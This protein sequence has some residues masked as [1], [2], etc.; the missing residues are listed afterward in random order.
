MAILLRLDS[1][2]ASLEV[3]VLCSH[4][5]AARS[6][7]DAVR[8][9]LAGAMCSA[10]RALTVMIGDWNFVRE[11]EDRMSFADTEWKGNAETAEHDQCLAELFGPGRFYQAWQADD[12][13]RTNMGTSRLD[14]ACVNAH[15][16]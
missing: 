4:T 8:V 15:M 2:A 9:A 7:R 10:R 5:G 1:A 16:A 14:P 11:A 13:H 3:C 12:N 6:E